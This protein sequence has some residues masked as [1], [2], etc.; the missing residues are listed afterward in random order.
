M[1]E[2]NISID[3]EA[4]QAWI[5]EVTNEIKITKQILDKVSHCLEH[6]PDDDL[7]FEFERV[8]K[9]LTLYWDGLNKAME[10][11]CE[12]MKSAISELWKAAEELIETIKENA[13]KLA[14]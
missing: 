8:V 3:A 10:T 2:K 13:A 6:E 7:W 5:D 4:A 11:A 12:V 1:A 14:T 9:T